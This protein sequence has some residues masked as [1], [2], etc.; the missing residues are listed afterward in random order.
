MHARFELSTFLLTLQTLQ[1]QG[2]PLPLSQHRAHLTSIF[3]DRGRRE[4]QQSLFLRVDLQI[5]L[6][7][8]QAQVH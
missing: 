6:P 7:G 8:F 4:V 2:D 3:R 5:Q 1:Q